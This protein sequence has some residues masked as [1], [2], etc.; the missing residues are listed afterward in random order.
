MYTVPGLS[1]CLVPPRPWLHGQ[2]TSL[3]SLWVGFLPFLVSIGT[4]EKHSH[5]PVPVEAIRVRMNSCMVKKK[6]VNWPEGNTLKPNKSTFHFLIDLNHMKQ[7]QHS[8]RSFKRP[9]LKKPFKPVIRKPSFVSYEMDNSLYHNLNFR[10]FLL[11]VL[12]CIF[13]W[14]GG[15][16]IPAL[17]CFCVGF[18][19]RPRFV[20][21]E[22]W[23]K[24]LNKMRWR[25]M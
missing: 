4:V 23:H 11:S 17:V 5:S 2:S 3:I 20:N 22:T 18:W 16:Y 1:A 9:R 13:V 6:K 25:C 12:L 8:S 15:Y 14:P 10:D 7:Q 24:G 19:I 21:P